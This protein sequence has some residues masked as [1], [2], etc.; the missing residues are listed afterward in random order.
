MAIVLQYKGVDIPVFSVEPNWADDVT[1]RVLDRVLI[2]EALDTSEERLGTRPRPLY[3]LKYSTKELTEQETGYIRRVVEL[4]DALP[5]I[6]PV[7][8]DKVRLLQDVPAGERV[9]NVDSTADS[10]WQLA[11]AGGGLDTY[12]LVWRSFNEWEL[13][14]T[15]AGGV[16]DDVIVSSDGVDQD[17]AG[18]GHTYLIPILIGWLQRG[19]KRQLDTNHG[20]FSVNF[21]ERFLAVTD[22]ATEETLPEFTLTESGSNAA[23]FLDGEYAL[24]LEIPVLPESGSGSAAFISGDYVPVVVA[25]S[26][27]D[28]GS[29]SSAF[30]SGHY[31]EVI[32]PAS[33]DDAGEISAAFRSGLYKQ[34][35]VPLDA[36]SEDASQA[37]GFESGAYTE[38]VEPLDY[39]DEFCSQNAGF[40]IGSYTPA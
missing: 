3:G 26:G 39:P 14:A 36:G 1:L 8:P 35:I 28:A 11:G 22:N 5:F 12:A 2:H 40:L 4:P 23:G 17:W 10:L 24:H 15:N 30:V 29:T 16:T 6:M 38:T 13:V 9:F 32:V 18:D 34:V 20:I 37:A 7:W 31:D 25:T 21:E 27:E 33:G 19:P